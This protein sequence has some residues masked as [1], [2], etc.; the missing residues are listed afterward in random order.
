M[1]GLSPASVSAWD[2]ADPEA[3][4]SREMARLFDHGVPEPII[5]CHR[6]KVRRFSGFMQTRRRCSHNVR[7]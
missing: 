3:F 4:L 7:G 1:T 2:V 5:T 6:L